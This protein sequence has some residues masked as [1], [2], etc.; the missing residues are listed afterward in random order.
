MLMQ[1]L[2]T[3]MVI[4]KY[5]LFTILL[6]LFKAFIY[7]VIKCSAHEVFE[8]LDVAYEY[9]QPKLLPLC[10]SQPLCTPTQ[11]NWWHAVCTFLTGTVR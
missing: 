11:T 5:T 4:A 6:C 3:C 9:Y 2:I 7:A 10:L 8:N 1:T